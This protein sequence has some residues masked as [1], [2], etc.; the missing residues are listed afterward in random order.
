MFGDDLGLTISIV[1]W[2]PFIY[3]MLFCSNSSISSSSS[4]SNVMN[5]SILEQEIEWFWQVQNLFSE[6]NCSFS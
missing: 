6:S 4:S 2:L 3:F 5:T 1:S